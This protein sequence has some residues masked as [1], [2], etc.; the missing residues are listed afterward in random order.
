VTEFQGFDSK[1]AASA[2]LAEHIHVCVKDAGHLRDLAITSFAS[3]EE[4]GHLETGLIFEHARSSD[5][6]LY[7]DDDESDD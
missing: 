3:R 2:S 6:P 5:L 4:V 1:E 7:M